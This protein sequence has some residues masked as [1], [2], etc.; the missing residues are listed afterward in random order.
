MGLCFQ[1]DDPNHDFS[2]DDPI[3][4]DLAHFGGGLALADVDNNGSLELYVTYSRGI[5]GELFEYRG[6]TFQQID[7]NRGIQPSELE[8][9]GYFID[10]DA[11]GWKDFISVQRNGVEVFLNDGVGRFNKDELATGIFHRRST[12][13]MAAA[14]IDLDGDLDLVFG[15]W[16]SGWRSTQPLSEYLWLN[17]GE[18]RFFDYSSKLP[19]RPTEGSEHSFTPTFAH[20]NG[21]GFVDLLMAG[22]FRSSQVFVNVAGRH[23]EDVTTAEITDENGMGCGSR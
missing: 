21:D 18:G 12:T 20:I 4:Y 2:L 23:F 15:H 1:T 17:D 10:L 11:D 16:G 13:S 3:D 19:V 5:P 22:D 9:G 6:G 14:D 7:G 8:Y